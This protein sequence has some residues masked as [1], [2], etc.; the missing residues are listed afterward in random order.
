MQDGDNQ[1]VNAT[2]PLKIESFTRLHIAVGLR[3]VCSSSVFS[4]EGHRQ[5]HQ[6]FCSISW[7]LVYI[8]VV[9]VASWDR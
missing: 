6:R 8:S 4:E 3:S 2:C 5:R 9:A 7:R 1:G